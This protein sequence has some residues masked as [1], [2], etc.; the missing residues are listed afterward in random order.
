MAVTDAPSTETETETAATTAGDEPLALPGESAAVELGRPRGIS[1]L[2][3]ALLAAGQFMLLGGLLAALYT[4]RAEAF[5]W[6]PK[7]ASLGTYLPTMVAITIVMSAVSMQWAVWGIKRNDQ[8]TCLVALA[9]TL[10]MAFA[11]V[12][13]QWYE[14]AHLSFPIG[15]HA[16]GT[17]V[18]VLTGFH[19][20]QVMLGIILLVAVLVRAFGAE[21]TADDHDSVTA[22]AILWQFANIAGLV[23]YSVL[24]VHP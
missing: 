18:Y 14:L 2:A 9:F 17:F 19:M 21:F 12:N 3:M 15:R 8:R 16:Y 7:G 22:A 24:F 11:I 6:P 20:V 1:P 10:F 5:V 4:L 23:A 13:G